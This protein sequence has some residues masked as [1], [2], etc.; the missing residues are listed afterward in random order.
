MKSIRSIVV[1]PSLLDLAVSPFLTSVH[2][3]KSYRLLWCRKRRK[4]R[5]LLEGWFFLRIT[6]VI[7]LTW[8]YAVLVFDFALGVVVLRIQDSRTSFFTDVLGSALNHVFGR[9]LLFFHRAWDIAW[10]LREFREAASSIF[11][12]D[13]LLSL[14]TSFFLLTVGNVDLLNCIMSNLWLF[15]WSSLARSLLWWCR[16]NRHLSTLALWISEC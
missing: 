4:S 5:F 10:T 12:S 14:F 2:L 13:S 11:N 3:L 8:R 9:N 15:Q 16:T 1:C 7:L 6:V